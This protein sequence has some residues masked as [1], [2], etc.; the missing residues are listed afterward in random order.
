MVRWVDGLVGGAVAGVTSAAFYA[1]VIGWLHETT[2]ESFFAQLAQALPPLR[3]APAGPGLVVL[4][5]GLHFAVAIGFALIYTALARRL[6]SMWRAPTSVL[7]G[8]SYG[9]FVWWALNDVAVP[10]TG[11]LNVQPLWE[12]LVGTVVCYGLVL[13][14]LTTLAYRRRASVAP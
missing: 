7:W 11:M 13:S 14:E 12:G 10:E 2:L 5:V 3:H 4:G 1:A 8:L 6:R 9:L